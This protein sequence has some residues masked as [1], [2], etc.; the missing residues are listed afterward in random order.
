MELSGFRVHT[1]L[2][3]FVVRL[4]VALARRASAEKKNRIRPGILIRFNF[5]GGL[6]EDFNGRKN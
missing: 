5:V 1:S 4:A 2:N 3:L 6:A